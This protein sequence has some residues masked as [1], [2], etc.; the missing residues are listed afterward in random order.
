VDQQTERRGE[1]E[2]MRVKILKD[3]DTP[4]HRLTKGTIIEAS[5]RWADQWIADGLAV[6]VE[7]EMETTDA[8]PTREIRAKKATRS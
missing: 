2:Q 6:V 3:A 8:P 7:A 5:P 4:S 1:F